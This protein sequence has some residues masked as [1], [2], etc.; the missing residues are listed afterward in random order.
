MTLKP[1]STDFDARTKPAPLAASAWRKPVLNDVEGSVSSRAPALA[2]ELGE[3]PAL[4]GQGFRLRFCSAIKA[5]KG[6]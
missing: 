2:S 4:A 3:L 6:I 1:D 5:A